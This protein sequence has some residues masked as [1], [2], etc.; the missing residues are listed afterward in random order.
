MRDAPFDTN[1]TLRRLDALRASGVLTQAEAANCAGLA[2]ALRRPARVAILGQSAPDVTGI[3]RSLLGED[4]AQVVPGGPAIEIHLGDQPSHSATFEDGSSLSQDGYPA[5]DL[6]RYGPLFLQIEAPIPALETMSFLAVELGADAGTWAPALSWAAKRTEIAI[7]CAHDFSDAEAAIWSSAP[8]RLKNHCY[9][10]VTGRREDHGTAS[11]RA[12]GLFDAIIHVPAPSE[13]TSPLGALSHRLAADI[14]AARREDVDA[15]ELFLHRF[16]RKTGEAAPAEDAAGPE[17][18]DPV[19]MPPVSRPLSRPLSSPQ[20]RPLSRPLSRPVMEPAAWDVE[21][22]PPPRRDPL[23]ETRA[24]APAAAAE[25]QTP[26]RS[27]SSLDTARAL[28]SGPILHLKRRTRALAEILEWREEGEEWSAEVLAHCCETAEALRDLV[29]AWP[30]D[31]PLAAHLRDAIDRACD[32]VVLLQVE[33]GPDQAEDAAR[34]LYQLRTDF[35]Q[36]M[37]A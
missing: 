21:P 33:S 31:D 14:S 37:A 2:E 23:P 26:L 19:T 1:A 32:T 11:A 5:P 10:V 28:V 6:V 35:E 16:R 7:F 12:R 4:V 24:E 20:S 18:R 13:A 17:A 30:D 29:A 34:V 25:A 22:A 9:L 36:A 3:L 8:D 15:A 27:P